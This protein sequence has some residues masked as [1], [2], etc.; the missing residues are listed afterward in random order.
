MTQEAFNQ[1]PAQTISGPGPYDVLHPYIEG[2]LVLSIVSGETHIKL[3]P[4]EYT[5]TPL[6]SE[7][8]GTV[9][10]SASAAATH[11]GAKLYI[12]RAT[13]V[14]QGWSGQS[15][16]EIGLEAQ[17]DVIAQGVQDMGRAM[18]KALRFE[19][20]VDPAVAVPG[21]SIIFDD[22]GNPVPGPDA[23][24]IEAA[25][26]NATTATDAAQTAT[27]AAQTATDAAQTATT[28][29][30]TA[31]DNAA[32]TAQDATDLAS[33]LTTATDLRDETT[34]LRDQSRNARDAAE[35][36][37][38]TATGLIGKSASTAIH[39]AARDS[40]QWVI[41]RTANTCNYTGRLVFQVDG[42]PEVVIG[43]VNGTFSLPVSTDGTHLIYY[44]DI[45]AKTINSAENTA[46]PEQDASIIYIGTSINNAVTMRHGLRVYDPD[47]LDAPE[48]AALSDEADISANPLGAVQAARRHIRGLPVK[49]V[50][51]TGNPYNISN[52]AKKWLIPPQPVWDTN[53]RTSATGADAHEQ[54]ALDLTPVV[55]GSSLTIEGPARLF[56]GYDQTF[57]NGANQVDVD[58]EV[59]FRRNQ[60]RLS[61]WPADG[62]V[63]TYSTIGNPKMDRHIWE[64]GQSQK[65]RLCLNGGLGGK[66]WALRNGI[67]LSAP[68]TDSFYFSNGATGSTSI[69]RR[70]QT[71]PES[72]SYHID[73]TDPDPANW[74][75]GPA[76]LN[77]KAAH[78]LAI[79]RGQDPADLID[80]RQGEGDV[81]ALENG[82]ITFD[83]YVALIAFYIAWLRGVAGNAT[84]PVIFHMLGSWRGRTY[85]RGATMVR[86]AYQAVAA[87]D[88]NIHVGTEMYDASRDPG[89]VHP[90]LPGFFT[91]GMR[92]AVPLAN[93]LYGQA[94]SLG[95]E[96]ET[97]NL[98]ADVTTAKLIFTSG[99]VL[100]LGWPKTD[101]IPGPTPLGIMAIPAGETAETM[102]APIPLKG[103]ILEHDTGRATMVG[104]GR[105]L[106]GATFVLAGQMGDW[107]NFSFPRDS[108]AHGN[109]PGLPLRSIPRTA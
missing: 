68:I 35:A 104:D 56:A 22:N 77:A 74:T 102:T 43:S 88:A 28:A 64:I 90:N 34:D 89:E 52:A 70:S 67:A 14:E 54:S 106:T 107:E 72:E 58:G 96:I 18:E 71:D 91:I 55:N 16:R 84:L 51:E 25:Q 3:D 97:I 93:V 80:F 19:T 87:A 40:R 99:T 57:P 78:D 101:W 48:F 17:L 81:A 86:L 12:A 66:M 65:V 100:P 42:G 79:A 108:F 26:Q 98:G 82:L 7:A 5:V 9:T 62:T 50:Y 36:A 30:Q 76:A 95:P 45:V 103:A 33:A 37:A 21:K 27:G 32:Q 69:G 39:A 47:G 6:E 38:V 29:A 105:D 92:E 11:D 2:A 49:T 13:S 61:L 73:D 60:G 24:E 46:A 63:L 94:N 15:D 31:T 83:H 23:S 85:Y 41:D 53:L 20:D 44:A 75:P 4:A 8:T 59:I 1:T 10:L 109:A